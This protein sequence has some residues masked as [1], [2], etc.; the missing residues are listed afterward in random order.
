MY[1]LFE[2]LLRGR[3]QKDFVKTFCSGFETESLE[4]RLKTP[5]PGGLLYLG[6]YRDQ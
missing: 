6:L 1:K 4:T 3:D 2:T 5:R